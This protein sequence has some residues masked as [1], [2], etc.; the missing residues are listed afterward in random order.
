MRRGALCALLAWSLWLQ[1]VPSIFEDLRF[2]K[3]PEL[4]RVSIRDRSQCEPVGRHLE[5]TTRWRLLAVVCVEDDE[6]A[7]EP[8][9]TL[10]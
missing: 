4:V 5:K 8:T 10:R 3:E 2:L 7:P 1:R 9:G 6:R